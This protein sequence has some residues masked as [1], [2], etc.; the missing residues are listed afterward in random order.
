LAAELAEGT[1]EQV[2]RAQAGAHRLGQGE[3]RE[4]LVEVAL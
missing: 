3:H 2:R 1:L 4:Q